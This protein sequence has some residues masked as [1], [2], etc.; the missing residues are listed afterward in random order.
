M[1]VFEALAFTFLCLLFGALGAYLSERWGLL[2]WLA[3]AP[4]VV[5]LSL[6][7]FRMCRGLLCELKHSFHSRPVCRTGKCSSRRYFLLD[8]TKELA[9]FRCL[10]G[11]RYISRGNSF[12]HV[13]ADGT[14]EPYMVRDASG[15]WAPA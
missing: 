2:G 9:V 5:G 7:V 13:K 15:A 11:D 6:L 10:C 14:E 12:L 1:N 8:A 4:G 3:A